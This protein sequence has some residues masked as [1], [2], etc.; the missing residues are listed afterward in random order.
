MVDV[1]GL[2]R[3]ARLRDQGV[4]TAEEFENE[5]AKLLNQTEQYEPSDYYED[6]PRRTG[7]IIGAAL[8]VLLVGG[9]AAL[10]ASGQIGVN[11]ILPASITSPVK[12]AL[13]SSDSEWSF[14]TR[15]DPM[16]DAKLVVAKRRIDA[17]DYL[18]DAQVTCARGTTLQYEFDIFRKDE[19]GD[20]IA[21]KSGIGF[22]GMPYLSKTYE[23]RLDSGESATKAV[24]SRHSNVITTGASDTIDSSVDLLGRP[25]PDLSN[26]QRMGAAR[27]I[28]IQVPM[29]HNDLTF[30]VAQTD[31]QIRDFLDSC[32]KAEANPQPV[33]SKEDEAPA[34]DSA[35]NE[36]RTSSQDSS[37]ESL[38]INTANEAA[39]QR[40]A[41]GSFD[42]FA[43][44]Q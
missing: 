9:A 10:Y 24:K 44:R 37:G 7:K 11:D 1:D 19:Q 27:R 20:A 31:N 39:V 26:P 25:I 3:L 17:G 28:T 8:A 30:E 21:L 35:A 29:L 13:A 40:N 16:T 33:V 41:D 32:H 18:V 43:N 15:T 23:I 6:P 36:A 14:A 4:L 12:S 38:A 22:N 2:E 42:L 34:D 5:K